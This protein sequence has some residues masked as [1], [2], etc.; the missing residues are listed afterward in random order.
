MG[1]RSLARLGSDRRRANP[2]MRRERGEQR[3]WSEKG[4]ARRADG[5]TYLQPLKLNETPRQYRDPRSS[6]SHRPAIARQTL[7]LTLLPPGKG[8]PE[9]RAVAPPRVEVAT[10]QT[11]REVVVHALCRARGAAAPG[12]RC[13][14]GVAP[15]PTCSRQR[16][17]SDGRTVSCRAG[18]PALIWARVSGPW[19]FARPLAR[20]G[21]CCVGFC[22]VARPRSRPLNAAAP[23]ST[24]KNNTKKQKKPVSPENVER[25]ARRRPN[26]MRQAAIG[27]AGTTWPRL[28]GRRLLN[29]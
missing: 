22:C 10:T 28:R 12:R 24:P 1:F 13:R 18:R 2:S 14:R 19:P 6:A 7:T 9:F 4:R 25:T 5:T 3:W 29:G 15:S 20:P 17:E 8:H 26:S 16:W 23:K 21:T 27:A 11:Q